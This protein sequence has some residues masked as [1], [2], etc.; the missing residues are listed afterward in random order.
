MHLLM[1]LSRNSIRFRPISGAN[2]TG[3][4]FDEIALPRKLDGYTADL[5]RIGSFLQPIR[6]IVNYVSRELA[7]GKLIA[8]IY[9]P[10]IAPNLA[11]VHFPVPPTANKADMAKWISNR[12][13][14]KASHPQPAPVNVWALYRAHFVISADICGAW[15][16]PG[17]ISEQI[18]RLSIVLHIAT[19]EAIGIDLIYGPMR[20][21]HLEELARDRVSDAAGTN[22]FQE[23]LA[24]ANRGFYDAGHPT[25]LQTSK[26]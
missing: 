3:P 23:L 5:R 17:G 8:P 24:I 22:G 6:P 9:T 21:S 15:N 2:A 16:S 4:D 11:D 10:Y 1:H 7:I 18:N 26:S 12:Q 20:K 25:P 13:A 19:T 14:A